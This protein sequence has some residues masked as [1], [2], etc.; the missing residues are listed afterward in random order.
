MVAPGW[1]FSADLHCIADWRWRTMSIWSEGHKLWDKGVIRKWI[2]FLPAQGVELVHSLP[3]W[4][5]HQ[6]ISPW[7]PLSTP[8]RA[9]VSA[10]NW[11]FPGVAWSFSSTQFCAPPKLC[12]PFKESGHPQSS[13][14]PVTTGI[15]GR[16]PPR[17]QRPS[18]P[19]LLRQPAFTGMQIKLHNQIKNRLTEGIVLGN[20]INFQR[21]PHS[22]TL[23]RW[24]SCSYAQYIATTISII[25]PPHK[26]YL[27]PR[28]SYRALTHRRHPKLKPNDHT[29][30]TVTPSKRRKSHSNESKFKSKK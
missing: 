30:H 6:Y 19:Q 13:Q 21:L 7:A 20:E 5:R 23:R 17:K 15:S 26:S 8:I 2:V 3:L 29:Q 10:H 9:G 11:G 28:N 12:V 14:L 4:W 24:Y 27:Y 16:S 1:V 22:Q 18:T 25:K